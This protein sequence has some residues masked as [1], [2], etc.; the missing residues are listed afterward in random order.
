MKD[1]NKQTQ[2]A[3][4]TYDIANYLKKKTDF[5]EKLRK[6]NENVTLDKTKHVE[7]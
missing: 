7:T 2:Q 3:K 4:M 1:S 6:I 5:D